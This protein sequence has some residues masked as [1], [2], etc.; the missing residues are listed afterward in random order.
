MKYVTLE[1]AN[2]YFASRMGGELWEAATDAIKTKSINHAERLIERQIYKG[3]RV[4][5][6]DAF[7]RDS[8][9][10]VPTRVL[11]AIYEEA[12]SLI[13]GNENKTELSDLHVVSSSGAGFQTNVDVKIKRPWV[14]AG[15]SSPIAWD[16][17]S[18]YLLRPGSFNI[19]AV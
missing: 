14:L 6:D 18:P 10:E 4:N 5:A 13:E 9:T 8:Q 2:V 7:P 1:T 16:L 15:F 11:E 12:F 19:A 3:L 17:I